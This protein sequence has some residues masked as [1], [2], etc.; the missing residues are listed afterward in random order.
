MTYSKLPYLIKNAMGN[1]IS[2]VPVES[3]SSGLTD[4]SDRLVIPIQM[5][6]CDRCFKRISEFYVGTSSAIFGMEHLCHS[7]KFGY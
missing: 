2:T 3:S 1:S 7:C 4:T 5:K 6:R